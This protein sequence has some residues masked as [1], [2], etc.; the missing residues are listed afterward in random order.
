MGSSFYPAATIGGVKAGAPRSKSMD[1]ISVAN[2]RLKVAREKHDRDYEE[3]IAAQDRWESHLTERLHELNRKKH[4]IAQASG[5]LDAAD[6]DLMEVNAGG[7]IVVA[8]RST[9][10]Q[11]EGTRLE[12]LFSGRWDKIIQRDSHGRIFLDVN[13]SCFRAIVDYLNEVLISSEDSPLN[14]PSVEDKHAHILQRQLELFGLLDKV[15]TMGVDFPDSNIIKDDAGRI[16]IHDLLKEDGSDGDLTLLY[17]GSHNGLSKQAFHS[18]CDNKG[19]TLTIIETTCGKVIGGYSNT[20]WSESSGTWSVANKAFLFALSGMGSSSPC[21][22]KLKDADDEHAIFNGSHCGPSFG[23]RDDMQVRNDSQVHIN[24]GHSYHSGPLATELYD[25]KEMEVF[26]VT[27]SSPSARIANSKGKHTEGRTLQVEAVTRFSHEVNEAI[28]TK[29][30]SLIQAEL[31]ILQHEESFNDEQTF[32]KKFASGDAKDVIVLNVSGTIMVTTRST[33]CTA[34]DSVLAQQV[35]DSKSTEQGCN[36]PPVKEWT[37]DEVGDWTKNIEG[38]QE[39]VSSILRENKITGRELLSLSL[40]ELKMM[41]IERAGTLC[42]ILDE[43]KMLKQAS[44]EI[45]TLIEHSPY[46]FGK[47]LDYLRL[48]RLHSLGL[49]GQGPIMPRVYDAQ[50]NR[51]E[52]VVKYYF[53]GDSSKFILG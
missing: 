25:I 49:L 7:E 45:V 47:I 34:E 14:P 24:M 11:I 42:L 43:I 48:K 8:K 44:K 6:N 18:K 13:P 22:M 28:N 29:Q 1:E 5:N 51:F 9:L 10:T 50:K 35:D 31:A 15:P 33:L 12:A 36:G 16:I 17:Q 46:C 37:P 4:D 21:K 38:L 2:K 39:D 40:G 23:L 32:I 52:K 30:L 26:Q 20:S 3:C 19:C 53:P 27:K 41:G